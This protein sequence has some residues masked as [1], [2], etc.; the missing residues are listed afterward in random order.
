MSEH[1]PGPWRIWMS[2]SYRRIGSEA[3]GREVLYATTQR[4]GQPD[5]VFTN[6]GE[7]GPDARLIAAAPDLLNACK[8]ALDSITNANGLWTNPQLGKL[9]SAA[10]TKAEG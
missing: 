9:L 5:L 4:D 6:G 8:L 10:I 2:N 1:T 7:D 3:T